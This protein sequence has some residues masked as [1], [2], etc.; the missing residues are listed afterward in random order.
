MTTKRV[1]IVGAG[2]TGAT[3]ARTLA[4]AGVSVEV[5]EKRDRVGGNCADYLHEAGCYVNFYG[6]H[7]FRTNDV[8]IWEWANRFADF[9]PYEA[10]LKTWV[11]GKYEDWPI[12]EE[13]VL[14][15]TNQL[16]GGSRDWCPFYNDAEGVINFEDMCLTKMPYAVYQKVVEPY[17]RK[18]W[19]CD[20]KTLDAALAA[21]VEV[22]TDGDTRLKKCKYQ[23]LPRGGYTAWIT[24]MLEGIKVHTGVDWMTPGQPV[25][26]FS[27]IGDMT[28][29]YT[30]PIDA[31]FGYDLGR[32]KYR[33]QRRQT[34]WFN[35][36]VSPFIF[37]AMQINTPTSND[38]KIRVIEWKHA[39]E[40]PDK[41]KGTVLTEELP[42]TPEDPEHY[43]YPFPD[44]INR[45]L[46][47]QYLDRAAAIPGLVC[48]GRLGTYRYFDMDQA[49]AHGLTVANKI[50]EDK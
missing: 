3:I 1:L 37:P 28:L 12:Q 32:L 29:V 19:G 49:I 7:Y 48:A 38:R 44:R 20:P 22:R 36:L 8:R 47:A 46:A 18:Q 11:D 17:T 34:E 15:V 30:G 6:P 35:G 31:L 24:K 39:A 41:V 13:Y 26:T 45:D 33:G 16:R 42:Y 14:R 27:L 2:L 9:Y 10:R 5:V 40:H 50:L 4:D 21:R 23:G 43:E 25:A